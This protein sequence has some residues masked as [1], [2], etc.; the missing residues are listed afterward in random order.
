[1][2][3]GF[4]KMAMSMGSYASRVVATAVVATDG[5][6][7]FTD[8]QEAIDSLPAG[9]GCIYIKQGTYNLTVALSITSDN[10]SI[11]GCGYS[12][13][14]NVGANNI[15][16]VYINGAD[17]FTL[18]DCRLVGTT[19][20]IIPAAAIKINNS[21]DGIISH[22]WLQAIRGD[23][24]QFKSACTGM[25]IINNNFMQPALWGLKMDQNGISENIIC[26]N[27]INGCVN[28]DGI[29]ISADCHYNV[30]E[31]NVITDCGRYGIY[32]ADINAKGN[33]ISGN[34][35][36]NNTT[37]QIRDISVDTQIG[38]NVMS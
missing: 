4:I 26:G 23:I 30:I 19:R 20:V 2:F 7:D 21:N 31:G 12:T 37:D 5:T 13:N 18:S 29:Q 11:T 17:K 16:V 6:G 24:I 33:I 22:C 38:H 10:I 34:I 3:W 9:G 8:I 14:I 15:N 25:M 36:R 1:M 32:I 28:F 35:I 27:I